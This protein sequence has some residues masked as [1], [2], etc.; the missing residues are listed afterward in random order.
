MMART[1][2][3]PVSAAIGER[4]RRKTKGC[5]CAKTARL[6]PTYCELLTPKRKV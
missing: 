5:F 4:I 2:V 1:C 3:G 6:L